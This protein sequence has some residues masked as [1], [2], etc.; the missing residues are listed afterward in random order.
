[1]MQA[2]STHIVHIG[3]NGAT[4]LLWGIHKENK[5]NTSTGTLCTF[6]RIFLK[7]NISNSMI[8]M[9]LQNVVSIIFDIKIRRN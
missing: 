1:M 9:S 6:E 8:C 7:G 2:Y 5:G 4:V 3:S